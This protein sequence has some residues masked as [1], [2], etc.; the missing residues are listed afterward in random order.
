MNTRIVKIIDL[1]SQGADIDSAASVIKNGG[2]VVIPTETVYG[3]VGDATNSESS[4]KIY[5]AKGRP[6]YNPLIIHI[7]E[8]NDA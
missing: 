2:L 1:A 4:Q 6:S 7:A 5:A 8:P 3:V